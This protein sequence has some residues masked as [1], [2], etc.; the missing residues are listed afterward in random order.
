M[1]FKD[2]KFIITQEEKNEVN[3]KVNVIMATF[4]DNIGIHLVTDMRIELTGMYILTVCNEYL[5][6]ISP[7]V[8][9]EIIFDGY[10]FAIVKI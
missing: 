4:P 9:G 6:S 2:D 3:N 8:A 1:I 10:K 5:K 7:G